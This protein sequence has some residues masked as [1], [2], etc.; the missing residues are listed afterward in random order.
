MGETL[1]EIKNLTKKFRLPRK[2]EEKIAVAALNLTVE[3]GEIFGLLGPNGAGK[4]TTVRMLTLQTKA[5]E[6]SIFFSGKNIYE[7]EREVKQ[8]F[9]IVPQHVNFDRELTVAENLELH[10]RL[11]HLPGG[12]IASRIDELLAYVGLSEQANY[13]INQLSG[14]MKRRL[15]IARALMH[16]PKILF[17]DEP[18]VALDPQ[19]RRRIWDLVRQLAADKVTVILTTHYIEEAENLCGR[20]AILNKG[21]LIALGSPEELCRASGKSTLEDAFIAL[22]GNAK[23]SGKEVAGSA[24]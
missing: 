6:G 8:M 1:I 13:R 3:R 5:G 22:V 2:G 10:A 21:R 20:V 24:R 16:R 18:T 17:M 15:L 7:F 23:D 4:T 11:H 14:G 12:E 9:G 19:V